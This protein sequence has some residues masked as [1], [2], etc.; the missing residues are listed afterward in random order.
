MVIKGPDIPDPGWHVGTARNQERTGQ[1]YVSKTSAIA[2]KI[3]RVRHTDVDL[4]QWC[5]KC[6]RPQCFIEVKRYLVSDHEWDQVRRHAAFYGH[7]CIALLVIETLDAI[8]IKAYDDGVISDVKWGEEEDLAGV[9][10]SARDR[11]ECWLC[12]GSGSAGCGTAAS[13][14]APARKAGANA[15]ARRRLSSPAP[16]QSPHSTAA[17]TAGAVIICAGGERC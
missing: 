7:D 17:S 13:A 8:G 16:G 11:H 12:A 5:P 15:S 10:E 14:G 4:T 9:L 6:K 3:P 2:R 1:R